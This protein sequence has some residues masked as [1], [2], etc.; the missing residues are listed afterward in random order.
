MD[1]STLVIA[2]FH[3]ST[4]PTPA[5]HPSEFTPHS[6]R[7]PPRGARGCSARGPQPAPWAMRRGSAQAA[8][9]AEALV[10]AVEPW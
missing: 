3:R 8:L 7:V 9:G 2:I 6:F 4:N 5:S 10:E 1:K